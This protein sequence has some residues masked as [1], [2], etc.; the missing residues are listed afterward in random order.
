MGRF[1]DAIT[2]L[3]TTKAHAEASPDTTV[4]ETVKRPSEW[5]RRVTLGS[6][7]NQELIDEVFRRKLVHKLLPPTEEG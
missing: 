2:G 6:F 3:F 5:D 7:S 1:R 4:R